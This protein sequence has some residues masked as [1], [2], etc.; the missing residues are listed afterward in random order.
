LFLKSVKHEEK[1]VV[2]KDMTNSKEA[3][4]ELHAY[5][6]EKAGNT[7]EPGSEQ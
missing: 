2:V 4:E 6:W 1:G 5:F 7:C 3:I